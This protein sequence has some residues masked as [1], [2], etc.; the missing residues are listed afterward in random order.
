[1]NERISL[2]S[3]VELWTER[4]LYDGR[5]HRFWRFEDFEREKFLYVSHHRATTERRNF[6][7]REILIIFRWGFKII[8]EVCR[9][10]WELISFV[11]FGAVYRP[12][13]SMVDYRDFEDLKKDWEKKVCECFPITSPAHHREKKFFFREILIKYRGGVC[14]IR[15]IEV[16]HNEWMRGHTIFS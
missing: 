11:V 3:F 10:F 7:F 6:F 14:L 4:N 1:M 5:L 12:S 8:F 15:I 9:N 16:C 2:C 13:S